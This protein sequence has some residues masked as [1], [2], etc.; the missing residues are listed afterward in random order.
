MATAGPSNAG[1]ASSE[2]SSA[3]PLDERHDEHN[4]ASHQYCGPATRRRKAR[5]GIARVADP[6][7]I[8]IGLIRVRD[9]GAVV[10]VT[11]EPVADLPP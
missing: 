6:I 1:A 11:G 9:V 8:G 10:V 4:G 2:R 7:A 3:A 5:H